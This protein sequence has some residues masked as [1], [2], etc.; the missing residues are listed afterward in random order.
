MSLKCLAHLADDTLSFMNVSNP[1][2]FIYVGWLAKGI[3]LWDYAHENQDSSTRYD[4]KTFCFSESPL[5][6]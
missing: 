3:Q 1:L 4:C 2:M 5:C 6:S